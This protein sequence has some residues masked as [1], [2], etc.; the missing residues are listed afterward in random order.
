MPEI[1]NLYWLQITSGQVA[2]CCKPSKVIFAHSDPS[3]EQAVVELNEWS[4]K[5]FQD[6]FLEAFNKGTVDFETRKQQVQNFC[7]QLTGTSTT[8]ENVD[9]ASIK[10]LLRSSKFQGVKL[11]EDGSTKICFFDCLHF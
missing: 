9:S 6:R 5:V 1:G 7:L 11:V 10:A 2:K 3:H 8:A 4:G